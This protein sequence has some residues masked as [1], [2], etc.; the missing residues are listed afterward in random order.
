M[1][2]YKNYLLRQL[3]LKES[4]LPASII[5]RDAYPG[6]DPD[7]L[8]QGTADEKDEHGMPLDKAKQTATQHLDQPNQGHYY[9]GMDKA[10]NAGMLKEKIPFLGGNIS[11]TAKSPQVL[12]ISVRGSPL[13]GLPTHN[14]APTSLTPSDT[15]V[16]PEGAGVDAKSPAALGGLELVSRQTP[17]STVVDNTPQNDTINS[18]APIADAVP[19]T[20]ADEHPAQVQQ[21]DGEPA[22]A[23]TGTSA[24]KE[25]PMGEKPEPEE[26]EIEKD[27]EEGEEDMSLKSA[28]PK[29]M[30]IDV[31]K[32]EG[33][34]EEEDEEEDEE[35]TNLVKEG[36]HKAGCQCGFCKNKGSF[37]KKKEDPKDK[38]ETDEKKEKIKESLPQ[39]KEP[40]FAYCVGCGKKMPLDHPSSSTQHK[41][42]DK[43]KGYKNGE[44]KM[45]E[46]FNRHMK[47][48]RE[49][50]GLNE[51]FG[52]E[53]CPWICPECGTPPSQISNDETQGYCDVCGKEIPLLR[54]SHYQ[55]AV[56][57]SP[58]PEPEPSIGTVPFELP[59]HLK[60]APLNDAFAR[61]SKLMRE[62]LGLSETK[63][64]E[65]KTCGCEMPNTL[66]PKKTKKL[67]SERLKA[68]QEQFLK[69]A[70]K[71]SLNEQELE[72]SERIA[73]T[74]NARSVTEGKEDLKTKLA[75]LKKNKD[76]ESAKRTHT[77]NVKKMDRDYRRS[78]LA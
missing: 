62:K 36:K 76:E 3:G 28:A 51:S 9:S 20:P 11:P 77:S 23:L 13:G 6:I 40:D 10:K 71:T 46:T 4:Q 27:E 78:D 32:E 7:E 44:S 48:M 21:V 75:K 61:H 43:C 34:E 26:F 58:Q 37:G 30:D 29:G 24:D 5:E 12:A 54:N 39:V 53:D 47:L 68:L 63:A 8:E 19:P 18:A 55:P 42:C 49:K 65:C 14:A 2:N 52:N 59:T 74:L 67:T 73:L 66:H 70:Q 69:K 38:G 35:P 64:E 1:S 17:N 57:S 56:K 33:E 60:E 41:V 31:P 16:A 25:A 15:A 50:V 45:D 72:I 22:Q